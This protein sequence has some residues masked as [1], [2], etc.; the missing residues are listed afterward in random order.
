MRFAMCQSEDLTTGDS[1][2]MDAVHIL[3]DMSL[4]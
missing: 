2:W 1:E 3:E 4:G